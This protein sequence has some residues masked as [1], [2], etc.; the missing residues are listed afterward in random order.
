MTLCVIVKMTNA[1]IRQVDRT[2]EVDL[3]L[4]FDLDLIIKAK[5]CVSEDIKLI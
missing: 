1:Q 5:N 3:C 4:S 2:S